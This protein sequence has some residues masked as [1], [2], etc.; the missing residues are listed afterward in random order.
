MKL[1]FQRRAGIAG[2][3]CLACA[4]LAGCNVSVE[5]SAALKAG[6]QRAQSVEAK[7]IVARALV[8][9]R[10]KDALAVAREVNDLALVRRARRDCDQ[11]PWDSEGMA[12][13][14]IDEL[15]PAKA[16]VADREADWRR[17]PAVDVVQFFYPEEALKKEISG[18]VIVSCRVNEAGTSHNCKVASEAPSG[19]GFGEAALKVAPLFEIN[20]KVV[21]GRAVE[22]TVRVPIN[23]KIQD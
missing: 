21:K 18:K 5:V 7:R 6:E 14:H 12:A 1:G 20:P 2:V 17:P 10:C 11:A 13:G 16:L 22:D 19:H 9:G 8:D 15:G 4:M 23:F 3:L